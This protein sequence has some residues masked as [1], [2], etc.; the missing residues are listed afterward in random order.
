MTQHYSHLVL[1]SKLIYETIS[2][3]SNG[4]MWI[5]MLMA[6]PCDLIITDYNAASSRK[7]TRTTAAS[8]NCNVVWHLTSQ[9]RCTFHET[10]PSQPN[11]I[12]MSRRPGHRDDTTETCLMASSRVR[13]V[14]LQPWLCELHSPF[15][16]WARRSMWARLE[17]LTHDDSCIEGTWSLRTILT[18]E[19]SGDNSIHHHERSNQPKHSHSRLTGGTSQMCLRRVHHRF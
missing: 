1:L 4:S 7:C 14:H 9:L 15:Q 8:A 16:L 2:L 18:L 6:S 12:L 19:S 3:C 13:V 11:L 17:G 10:W 5:M